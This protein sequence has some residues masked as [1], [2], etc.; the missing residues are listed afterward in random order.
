[1]KEKEFKEEKAQELFKLHY[2]ELCDPDKKHVRNAIRNKTL[3]KI[4]GKK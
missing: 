3:G 4:E 2:D 1:M